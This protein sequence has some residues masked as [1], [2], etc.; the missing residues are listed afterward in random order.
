M[1]ATP[2]LLTFATAAALAFGALAQPTPPEQP[3]MAV[4]AATRT[5]V[6]DGALQAL[7]RG[8]VFPEMAAK[9][10]AAVRGRDWSE[11]SSA[12]ALAKELTDELQAVTK[13]KHLRVVYRSTELQQRLKAK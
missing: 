6:I 9:A 7:D 2:L 13:D 1:R 11:V 4:D 10:A 8:Y 3:D 5:A 12:K